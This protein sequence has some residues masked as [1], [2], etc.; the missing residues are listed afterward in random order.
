LRRAG[1]NAAL[2]TITTWVV[3]A[4]RTTPHKCLEAIV[5]AVV[6]TTMR[7][8]AGIKEGKAQATLAVVMI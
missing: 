1:N 8:E 3:K 2:I 5:K 6:A 4:T 7:I